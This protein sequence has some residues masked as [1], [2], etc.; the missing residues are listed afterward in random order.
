MRFQAK[1][2]LSIHVSFLLTYF[3][4]CSNFALILRSIWFACFL[5]NFL[6]IKQNTEFHQWTKTFFV[7]PFYFYLFFLK[8]SF[9]IQSRI[10]TFEIWNTFLPA[11]VTS[12][13]K[14]VVQYIDNTRKPFSNTA[15]MFSFGSDNL[16]VWRR[17]VTN[18]DCRT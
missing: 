16:R 18:V 13:H 1:Q 7:A 9:G 2:T 3:K 17:H 15:N 10:D 4:F 14:I 11:T 12:R 6:F 5:S 8:S